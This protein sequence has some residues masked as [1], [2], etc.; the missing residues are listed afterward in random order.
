MTSDPPHD[1][2]SDFTPDQ[3]RRI[4]EM[5]E[6]HERIRWVWATIAIFA[7]WITAVA[8]AVVSLNWAFREALKWRVWH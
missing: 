6:E 7:K 8:A 1:T 3:R 2:M 4:L 5:L